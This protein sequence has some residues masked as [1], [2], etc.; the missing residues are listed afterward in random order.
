MTKDYPCPRVDL[1]ESVNET[2]S[3]AQNADR[4]IAKLMFKC[5]LIKLLWP[6]SV[7]LLPNFAI[8]LFWQKMHM[9]T[10]TSGKNRPNLQYSFLI[11]F[12]LNNPTT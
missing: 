3:K 6:R 8:S 10:R 2:F 11:N 12:S 4:P 7:P 1:F 9:P 5:L